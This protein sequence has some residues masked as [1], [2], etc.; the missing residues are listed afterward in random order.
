[1]IISKKGGIKM[2]Q[3]KKGQTSLTAGDLQSI[4]NRADKLIE[5]MRGSKPVSISHWCRENSI[6]ETAI[7][8][9]LN[10]STY[11]YFRLGEEATAYPEHLKMALENE[12]ERQ[13]RKQLENKERARIRGEKLAR[14]MQQRRASESSS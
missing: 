10:R 6:S 4:K 8:K 5:D 9:L 1:M 14:V 11:P 13:I 12:Y 7:Y 2:A 3:E